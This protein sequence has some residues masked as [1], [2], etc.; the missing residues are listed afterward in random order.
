M[1]NPIISLGTALRPDTIMKVIGI[2]MKYALFVQFMAPM[3]GMPTLPKSSD[4][5]LTEGN[6]SRSPMKRSVSILTAE[7]RN[8][9]A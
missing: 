1:R 2:M 5:L 9:F 3:A 4:I 8:I 6:P 7:K